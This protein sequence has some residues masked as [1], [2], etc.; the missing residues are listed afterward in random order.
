MKIHLLTT[1][2]CH[3]CEKAE[4]L[5]RPIA[6]RFDVNLE[7]VDIALDDAMVEKYG[8]AIP[9]LFHPETNLELGWPFDEQ[10]L[11]DWLQKL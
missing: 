5:I 4:R 10:E 3:L 6:P 8:M 2:G 7:L 1:A 9:V 11:I